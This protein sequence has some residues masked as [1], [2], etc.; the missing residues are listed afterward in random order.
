MMS[1]PDI[2]SIQG[3]SRILRASEV[4][5]ASGTNQVADMPEVEFD[6]LTGEPL[7]PRF[8]WR[9]RLLQRLEMAAQERTAFAAAPILGE[10]LDK[11]A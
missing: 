6:E 1:I 5:P 7:L 8:P 9:S 4:R 2:P 3:T 11:S 10:I